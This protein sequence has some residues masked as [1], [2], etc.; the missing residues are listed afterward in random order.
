MFNEAEI[1]RDAAVI[2][3]EHGWCRGLLKNAEGCYCAQG[4]IA[5]ALVNDTD[6]NAE[7]LET[8][9]LNNKVA[10][11]ALSQWVLDAAGAECAA[12]WVYN[13]EEARNA[14]DVIGSLRK[15][16]DAVDKSEREVY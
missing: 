13:D 1:L 3:E 2:L 8:V 6:L 16:A 5:A 7:Q 11:G 10:I 14:Q 12:L 4:A 9:L 15:A